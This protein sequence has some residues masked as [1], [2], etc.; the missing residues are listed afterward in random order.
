MGEGGDINSQSFMQHAQR[1]CFVLSECLHDGG[2]YKGSGCIHLDIGD[3][4]NFVILMCYS[5]VSIKAHFI[6]FCDA[7][8]Y[9]LSTE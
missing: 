1:Y 3:L 2:R 5:A 6:V 4:F 8:L 7:C 9:I